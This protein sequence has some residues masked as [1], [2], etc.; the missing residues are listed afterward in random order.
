MWDPYF[1]C[2]HF[3][4]P[5]GGFEM[6]RDIINFTLNSDKTAADRA[7]DCIERYWDVLGGLSFGGTSDP[8]LAPDSLPRGAYIFLVEIT[9]K[10]YQI[11]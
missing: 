6:G 1:D 10:W 3:L 7:K 8:L 2:Y 4:L 5:K 11:D 9:T